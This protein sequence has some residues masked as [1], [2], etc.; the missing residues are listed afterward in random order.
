MTLLCLRYEF[1]VK[2]AIPDSIH[3][4]RDYMNRQNLFCACQP[5]QNSLTV[6]YF[7]SA[8]FGVEESQIN[9]IVKHK[10]QSKKIPLSMSLSSTKLLQKS[11]EFQ[12]KI[13]QRL[14]YNKNICFSSEQDQI[15][16][17][18][19]PEIVDEL[20]TRFQ[21]IKNDYEPKLFK[22]SLKPSEI[23]YLLAM[24]RNDLKKMEKDYQ[25]DGVDILSKLANGEIIAPLNVREK[26]E[27]PI[28][29]LARTSTIQFDIQI[30]LPVT[31]GNGFPFLLAKKFHCYLKTEIDTQQLPVTIPKA[32]V[33][34]ESTNSYAST[35]SASSS[36]STSTLA[37]ANGSI[38]IC[39]GDLTQEVVDVIVVCIES[40][41]LRAA[42]INVAGNQVA[43][44]FTT[45]SS[46]PQAIVTSSG[47]LNCKKI[48]FLHWQPEND[49]TLLKQSVSRFV[50]EGIAYATANN[51]T[52]ISFP[53]IGCG[54]FGCSI[55]DISQM[56]IDAAKQQLVKLQ[57]NLQVSFV[58][59]PQQQQVYDEFCKC[60]NPK[61]SSI[62][63]GVTSHIKRAMMNVFSK[64]GGGSQR[65][66]TP[67]KIM[68]FDKDV[69]KITLTISANNE[70]K[71]L[72]C[73][74]MIEVLS[75]TCSSK[76][77]M[78][79][80]SDM[81]KWSQQTLNKYYKYCLDRKVL[82]TLDV[83]SGNI[84]LNGPKEFVSDCE[85]YF[86]EV[87]TDTLRQHQ[88]QAISQGVIWSFE[89]NNGWEKYSL[90]STGELEDA[91]QFKQQ[92][93]DIINENMERCRVHFDGNMREECGQRVRQVR[94]VLN[95]QQLPDT[96]EQSDS[97]RVSLKINS[98]EYIS[99]LQQFNNTMTGK[100]T[101]I[102]KIERIQNERW[103]RQYAVERDEY[104]RKFPTLNYE[105]ALFHGCPNDSANLIIEQCFNRSFAGAN[106]TVYGHGAYFSTQAS[107]S[108][109][110]AKPNASNE[111]CMFIAKVLFI[112][113]T[114]GNSSMKTP[115]PGFDATTDGAHIFVIY[116]DAQAYGEY[117]ITYK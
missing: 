69:V 45:Q 26:I 46:S 115:P 112:K 20:S 3:L 21:T 67:L 73:K 44:E 7:K 75:K 40:T 72:M 9:D 109:S 19:L 98:S 111:H 58:I 36:S 114:T 12:T 95:N 65:E 82:P 24:C 93:V 71:L 37:V 88:I 96:W 78:K 25:S 54:N 10:F 64:D 107:Y 28:S 35:A 74:N 31:A 59:F 14:D 13:R 11:E 85:K 56:M 83:F 87:T 105:K 86:Y 39:M 81:R 43:Q 76:S 57:T 22:I 2:L 91:Y 17:F 5:F 101:Q 66:S 89:S 23:D 49:R 68:M 15:L 53:A 110:Y 79:D 50:L 38:N 92:W 99:I 117:L 27:L 84:Q 48:L 80:K 100:Y 41:K 16:L 32:C 90:K 113:P 33:D 116:L 4:L 62:H 8:R 6:Y 106:A 18:G 52:S 94:R 102:I 108:H 77:D 63:E 61:Q 1:R 104:K 30:L 34:D 47:T 103:W 97:K 70:D 51:Y 55:D 42:V 29:Q 60:I